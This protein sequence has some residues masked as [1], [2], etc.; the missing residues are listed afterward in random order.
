MVHVQHCLT[1]GAAL[2]LWGNGAVAAVLGTTATGNVLSLRE[3]H[4]S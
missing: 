2:V 1:G 4:A 3:L